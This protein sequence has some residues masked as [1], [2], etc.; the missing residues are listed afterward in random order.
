MDK[1]K[2]IWEIKARTQAP[3]RVVAGLGTSEEKLAKDAEKYIKVM[4][5]RVK[6]TEGMRILDIGC[7]PL[8]RFSIEF[9]RLGCIVNAVDISKTTIKLAKRRYEKLKSGLKGRVVFDWCDASALCFKD[10]SFDLV[11]FVGVFYHVPRKEICRAISEISR[12]LKPQGICITDFFCKYYPLS[13]QGMLHR[14]AYKFFRGKA[15]SVE[16]NFYSFLEIIKMFEE[17]RLMLIDSEG[18]VDTGCIFFGH[19]KTQKFRIVGDAATMPVAL[20]FKYVPLFKK[21]QHSY[22]LVFKKI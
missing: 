13:F 22:S 6:I 19:P 21:C 7:G 3:E 5:Q 4:Q 18:S 1:N 16:F 2:N 8:A 12:V 20:L 17:S 14:K 11:F 9:A 15:H 10:K